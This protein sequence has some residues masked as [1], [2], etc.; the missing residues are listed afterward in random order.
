[1]ASPITPSTG[2]GS[3]LAIGDIVNALV[4]ADKLAKQTQITSQ[5]KLVTA[6]LSSIGVLQSAISAFQATLK[7]LGNKDNPV[8]NGY[9]AKSSNESKLTVESDNLAVP[10][11]YSVEISQVATS[12]S[13]ASAAIAGGADS[14]LPAGHV[15][16]VQNGKAKDYTFAAGA[17]LMSV[18]KQINAETKSTKIS[19]NIIS[20][21][22]GSRLILGSTLTGADSEITT[23]SDVTGFTIANGTKLDPTIPG[24]SGYMGDPPGDARLN[25]NGF[26]IHSAS[27]VV[28]KS[29]GGL[30]LRCLKKVPQQ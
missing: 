29:L 30:A 12:S 5:T 15:T 9:A 26:E 2:L 17:T 18:A 8:F 1:M 10:G 20:D 19:A 25:I 22:N 11:H 6:K 21:S 24:S 28:D 3:G 13:V 16:V 14:P 4:S 23:S 7:T 27:N